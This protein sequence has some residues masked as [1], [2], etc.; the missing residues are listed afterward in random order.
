MDIN[1]KITMYGTSGND[2]LINCRSKWIGAVGYTWGGVAVGLL[3]TL[4]LGLS[5][6]SRFINGVNGSLLIFSV[7]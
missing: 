6:L 4:A 5:G 7:N 3:E 1:K 2:G